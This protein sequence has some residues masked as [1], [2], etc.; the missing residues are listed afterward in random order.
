MYTCIS[1]DQKLSQVI[2]K[3][4]GIAIIYSWLMLF[5]DYT[6]CVS[7]LG[8]TTRGRHLSPVFQLMHI[9][10]TTSPGFLLTLCEMWRGFFNQTCIGC[11]SAIHGTDGLKSPQKDLAMWIKALRPKGATA[12]AGFELAQELP[13]WYCHDSS[14]LWSSWV[15]TWNGN[16][17][18]QGAFPYCT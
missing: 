2:I 11:D 17:R 8:W 1:T 13:E 16:E 18:E 15:M 7:I 4:Y 10:V 9:C 14:G 3:W 5:A 12:A 6:F